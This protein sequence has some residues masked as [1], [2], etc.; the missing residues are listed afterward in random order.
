[1]KHVTTNQENPEY[2]PITCPHCGGKNIALI[3][4]YHKCV[5]PKILATLFL[6]GAFISAWSILL[7]QFSDSNN[8]GKNILFL[9]M[10]IAGYFVVQCYIF[11]TESKT[12]VQGI[13]RDCGKIWLIN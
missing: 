9:L 2:K 7:N 12:H 13:C 4:E 8:D 6:I 1:M 3:T 11:Y 10:S 5:F